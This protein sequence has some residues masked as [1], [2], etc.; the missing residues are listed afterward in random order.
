MCVI[1]ALTCIIPC[2]AMI[3]ESSRVPANLCN[4]CNDFLVAFISPSSDSAHI[5]KI[6][7]KLFDSVSFHAPMGTYL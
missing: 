2:P 7:G 6:F 4:N 3:A 5:F 1:L